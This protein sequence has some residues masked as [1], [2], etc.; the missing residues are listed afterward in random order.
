MQM[1]ENNRFFSFALDSAHVKFDVWNGPYIFSAH[2]HFICSWRE[3]GPLDGSFERLAY[4][5]EKRRAAGRKTIIDIAVVVFGFC[6][7]KSVWKKIG[8]VLM[9][10]A[11]NWLSNYEIKVLI[12]LWMLNSFRSKSSNEDKAVVSHTSGA[13]IVRSNQLKRSADTL[14][15][16]Y[17]FQDLT[18]PWTATPLRFFKVG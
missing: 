3:N 7:L 2:C 9:N 14:T 11:L 15:F 5:S 1:S 18:L 17:A 13:V 4:W 8:V 10:R 6:L 12:K 16:A